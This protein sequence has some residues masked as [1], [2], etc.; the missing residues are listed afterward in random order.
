M[1]EEHTRVGVQEADKPPNGICGTVGAVMV[2]P[3]G[4]LALVLVATHVQCDADHGL[5]DIAVTKTAAT[6]AGAVPNLVV[7]L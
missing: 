1:F 5:V 3:A 2:V 7:Q 6:I 4:H